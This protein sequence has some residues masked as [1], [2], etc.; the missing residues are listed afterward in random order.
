MDKKEDER[1]N[2]FIAKVKKKYSPELILLF[3]SRAGGEVWKHSDYDFII[4]SS[5]F[6]G[7]HWLDRISEIVGMW[8]PMID[9]DVL[10]YTPEEFE[11]KKRNSSVVRKA[12]REGRK[13]VAA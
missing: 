11:E 10:P 3:G 13:I 5:K 2:D 8:E 7:M 12:L 9:I 1:V 6:R 4:V